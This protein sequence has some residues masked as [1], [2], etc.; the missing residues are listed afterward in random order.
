MSGSWRS[1]VAGRAPGRRGGRGEGGG[2][3]GRHAGGRLVRAAVITCSNRS[4]R[5]ERGDDSGE[6]LATRLAEAGHEIVLR[7]MVPDDVDAIRAVVQ[8][9]VAAGAD[10]VLTTGGTGLTPT[11]VTPEAV[12]PL[13][14][15]EVPGIA[16]T[17]RAV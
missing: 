3:G 6:L 13:L 12:R 10:V 8:E 1:P 16:E 4:A 2:A 14:E 9:A 5:G 7:R 15:R 17:L 11:D